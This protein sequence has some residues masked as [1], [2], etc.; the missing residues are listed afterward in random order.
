MLRIERSTNKQA[1]VD[2]LAKS[3]QIVQRRART[4]LTG[5]AL[6]G[7]VLAAVALMPSQ[8]RAANEC[9]AIP[10]GP[11]STVNC[12]GVFVNGIEYE[13]AAANEIFTLNIGNGTIGGSATVVAPTV[14][15]LGQ[16]GVVI[17]DLF[18]G[19]LAGGVPAT[20]VMN[21]NEFSN[22]TGTALGAVVW[23]DGTGKDATINNS[24]TVTGLSAGL[25]T[26]LGTG[27]GL[28]AVTGD[29]GGPAGAGNATVNNMPTG[30]VNAVN[31]GLV[32]FSLE[33]EGTATANNQGSVTT[34]NGDG[35]STFDPLTGLLPT[36]GPAIASNSGNINAGRHG[37]NAGAVGDVTVNLAAASVIN[38]GNAATGAGVLAQSVLGNVVITGDPASQTNSASGP[39]IVGF[40]AT[41]TTT[42]DAGVVNSG[43]GSVGLAFGFI[44][45]SGGVIGAGL[46]DTTVNL[47]G[48]VSTTGLFGAAA[49][50]AAG[51]ATLNMN[52]QTI[53]PPLIGGSA[54][55]L[56][57]TMD[58][59]INGDGSTVD[60]FGVGL[61]GLNFGTGNT[62][63]N[64]N[65]ANIGTNT[66]PFLG[67][68]GVSTTG[69]VTIAAQDSTVTAT[70]V[71]IA[72][73]AFGGNVTVD[74]NVVNTTAAGGFSVGVA[75]AT[76]FG[77]GNADVNLHG[78][79][80]MAPG[81]FTIGGLALAAGTGN[82]T[83]T[84][85]AGIT[86]DPVIGMA[87][88]TVGPGLAQV[89]NNGNVNSTLV[90]LLGVNILNGAVEINNN[91]TGNV[92]AATGAGI[93]ALKLGP[94]QNPVP[95]TNFSVVV[96]NAGVV[97]APNG[98]GVGVV[99]IDPFL[100]GPGNNVQ[101]NN[102]GGSIIGGGGLLSPTIGI[103]A[104]PI[105]PGLGLGGG[106]IEI[107][108]T[109]G[110]IIDNQFGIANGTFNGLSVGLLGGGAVT[111]NNT[112]A[113][114]NGDMAVASTF[115]TVTLNNNAGGVWN[116]ETLNFFGALG[117]VTINNAGVIN[118]FGATGTFSA[119]NLATPSIEA[120]GLA[121]TG[122]TVN[123][124]LSGDTATINNAGRLQ[125][126]NPGVPSAAAFHLGAAN[127]GVVNNTGNQANS[128]ASCNTLNGICVNGT[129][130]F[131]GEIIPG[132]A[133]I[134]TPLTFN[135]AGGLVSMI[136][137][138][139]NYGGPVTPFYNTGLGDVTVINGNFNATGNSQLGV[140]AFLA[141]PTNSAADLLIIGNSGVAGTVTG[142]TGIIVAN[143]NN[144]GAYNPI[145]I[146]VVAVNSGQS[147][148]ANWFIDPQSNFY[149]PRFGGVIDKGL[150]FYSL[151][152]RNDPNVA[153]GIDHV[154]VSAPDR[155]VFELTKVPFAA[156][157][158]WHET[159]GTWLERQ[160]DLRSNLLDCGFSGGADLPVKAPPLKVT[161]CAPVTPGVWMKAVGS[162][163]NRSAQDSFTLP[164]PFAARFDFD[165]SYKQNVFGFLGG[166]DWG[167][168]GV[169]W[170]GDAFMVGVLGGYLQS[171]L[172][173][174]A[175]PTNFDFS[176]GTAG[177]YATYLNGRFFMDAIFKA[178]FLDMTWNVPTLAA[179]G[180]GNPKI[181]VNS[182]GTTFDAGY[183]WA[184]SPFWFIEPLATLS[185]VRTR[186]DNLAV[187]GT[188][189]SFEDSD[190]VRGS[191]G[192][193]LG[194]KTYWGASKVEASIIGRVWREFQD[195]G[196]V[197]VASAGSVLPFG[198]NFEGTFGEVSG[199]L[200]MYNLWN[201]GW[202]GFVKGGVKFN[203]DITTSNAMGGLR[204]T[205]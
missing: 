148:L 49:I 58:A 5:T 97:N 193:R 151:Q 80:T 165:T 76:L 60:A 159:T 84:S 117:N 90:G 167:R 184:L 140:D 168:N 27:H 128:N 10:A 142:R 196:N 123:I 110:G 146:P 144:P 125:V 30:V 64:A 15:G 4:L 141:G 176:G 65:A 46:G 102:T 1:G 164:A 3:K 199:L 173:F 187:L 20:S 131:T 153:G 194:A 14:L 28:V 91:A 186:I 63:I 47:H 96:N 85:D 35:I 88:V 105:L 17:G 158:I 114:I 198:D 62:I 37:I 52:G 43:S 119:L 156:Q 191:L 178:D 79:V 51:A 81:G 57:G 134:N 183:R 89:N 163:T 106:D 75:G 130:L 86:I 53:D 169:F 82:A 150:F 61:L 45:V 154:L 41:G 200:N 205:W 177:A 195:P 83:I 107:N 115:G 101:V 121:L 93:F 162:W 179:F 174:D 44:P 7:A 170:G 26:L 100:V 202:T 36:F 182:Y 108:N 171:K 34:Q 40:S 137:G 197:V 18:L 70:N 138:I 73:L 25:P 11:N 132:F 181:G 190:S 124:L 175:S 74:A 69:N 42:I 99:A 203:E 50:S 67:I 59:T 12:S 71:G 8:V 155:E 68:L 6:A 92:Q 56:G 192:G 87:A 118:N 111:I 136:N 13:P 95:G 126:G 139:S 24:G 201:T 33:S 77:A 109:A 29:L 103:V 152:T 166:I 78:D 32:A 122:G 204:Y 21:I 72:G 113:T 133:V 66:A 120:F 112:A 55:V 188:G 23:T 127:A 145:G 2:P 116:T 9:G 48:K 129:A 104:S 54:I 19:Q 22:V 157:T 39:G 180:A 94:N 172:E 147:S 149:D 16:P 38:A 189:I 143:G 98:P 135:N 161:P 185:W 160:A 31:N